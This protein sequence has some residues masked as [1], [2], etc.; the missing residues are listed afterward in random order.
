MVFLDVL[1]FNFEYSLNY[2]PQVG[3]IFLEGNVLF[4]E[5][6]KK[7]KEI[8]TSWEKDKKI[9]D[10]IGPSILNTILAKCNIKSLTMSQELNLPP[11]MRLPIVKVSNTKK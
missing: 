10:E 5:D 2:E 3:K 9:P 6:P 1:S 11:H 8:I 4:M 7:V